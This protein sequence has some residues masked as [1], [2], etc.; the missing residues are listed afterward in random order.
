MCSTKINNDCKINYSGSPKKRHGV[1]VIVIGKYKEKSLEVEKHSDRLKRV[2][3]EMKSKLKRYIS[4]CYTVRMF[5]LRK[6]GF[7][8]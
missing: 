8:N 1:G 4:I 2:K 5:R 7:L 3:F 6:T